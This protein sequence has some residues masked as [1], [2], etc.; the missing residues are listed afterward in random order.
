MVLSVL[1]LGTEPCSQFRFLRVV[2][3][4][5]HPSHDD[6]SLRSFLP[7]TITQEVA[8]PNEGAVKYTLRRAERT[9]IPPLFFFD[10][11][12]WAP[13]SGGFQDFIN[14]SH[15][16]NIS[17]GSPHLRFADGDDR[18]RPIRHHDNHGAHRHQCNVDPHFPRDEIYS[19]AGERQYGCDDTSLKPDSDIIAIRN[20]LV[21][22][23][24]RRRSGRCINESLNKLKTCAV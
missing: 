21:L 2:R 23:I 3:D 17:F 11:C 13:V 24:S 1:S 10:T 6:S 14:S 7:Q 19:G 5:D 22:V 4:Q 16:T 9:G 18:S 20:N 12:R 8:P 15:G